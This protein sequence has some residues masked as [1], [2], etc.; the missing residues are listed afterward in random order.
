[1]IEVVVITRELPE[2][3]RKAVCAK[4]TYVTIPDLSGLT[5][6]DKILFGG[7]QPP[8]LILV[9][10]MM[11]SDDTELV[12]RHSWQELLAGK[13]RLRSL[14]IVTEIQARLPTDAKQP[15]I[16]LFTNSFRADWQPLFMGKFVDLAIDQLS[17]PIVANSFAE[18]L[19][20]KWLEK[21]SP[22]LSPSFYKDDVLD[23][24]SQDCL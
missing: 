3:L 7:K 1:V 11:D 8:R 21:N 17:G 12:L 10:L 5:K 22:E 2:W 18:V 6:I 19:K 20:Q 9:D 16:G 23:D 14:Q 24:F 15:L 13:H 4:L